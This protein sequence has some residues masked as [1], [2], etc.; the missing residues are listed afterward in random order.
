[1]S[2]IIKILEERG[3]NY[4]AFSGHAEVTQELKRVLR[5]FLDENSRFRELSYK[6][7]NVVLEALDMITHKMGRIVNGD[8][9]FEDSWVDIAGYASLVPKNTGGKAL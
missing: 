7:A 4:G 2:D 3:S 1:M 9:L 5:G 6:D 8:P